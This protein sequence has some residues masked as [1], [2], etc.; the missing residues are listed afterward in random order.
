M[1]TSDNN[2]NSNLDYSSILGLLRT[3]ESLQQ[4]LQKFREYP[5]GSEEED[6][7]WS[8]CEKLLLEIENYKEVLS[9]EVSYLILD[10]TRSLF[11]QK[12][13]KLLTSHLKEEL[14]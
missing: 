10:Y 6:L 13:S 2:N 9:E 8:Y 11:Y 5:V 4:S 12:E 3:I 1:I 7:W 14:K